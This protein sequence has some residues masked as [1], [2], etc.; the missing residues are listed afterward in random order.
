MPPI[1]RYR[2]AADPAVLSAGFR[3]FF[4]LAGLAAAIAIPLWLADFAGAIAIPSAFAPLV[5]HV[6]EMVFGFGLAALAGF[7]FTAVPN[8]TGRMP[9]QGAALGV[10]VLVWLAGRV[11]VFVSA[12]IGAGTAAAIDLAFPALLLGAIGREILTGRNWRNLPV[13]GA[14][15]ALLAADAWADLAVAGIVAHPLMGCRAGVAVLLSLI[16]MMGGRLAPSFTRNWLAR[17]DPEGAM[18]APFGKLDRAALAATPV[19][20]AAWALAPDSAASAWTALVAGALLL[21]RL[22][23]WQGARS[24]REPLLLVLHLGYCWLGAGFLWLGIADLTG[25]MAPADAA[26]ALTVG[27]VGSMILGVMTRATLGH[28]GQALHA[29]AGTVAAY[30]LI[31]IA[32]LLRLAAALAGAWTLAL[33]DLAGAAWSLGFALFVVLYAP[34]LLRPR[35]RR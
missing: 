4:L 35:A 27:A 2:A 21:A 7:L 8:W 33:L 9:L 11:A 1:P 15:A 32:A 18:P 29:G 24:R 5:W 25:W 34:L 20:A 12:A 26:H 6:H 13:L 14:L 16:A 3:P 22:A 30:A 28:T 23:R 10:L 31:G 19:A 17:M